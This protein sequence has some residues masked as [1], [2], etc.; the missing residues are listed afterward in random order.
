MK[1]YRDAKELIEKLPDT[2]GWEVWLAQSDV[3]HSEVCVLIPYREIPA[4]F[5]KTVGQYGDMRVE[6]LNED[7]TEAVIYI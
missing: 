4:G 6:G 5:L 1:H 3:H 7:S 2:D